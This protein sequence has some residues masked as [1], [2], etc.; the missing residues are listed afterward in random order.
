MNHSQIWNG[1]HTKLVT[2]QCGQLK[3]PCEK[4]SPFY[5]NLRNLWQVDYS[6]RAFQS[7]LWSMRLKYRENPWWGGSLKQSLSL[8]V[9]E[10][11]FS[12]ISRDICFVTSWQWRQLLWKTHNGT[13]IVNADTAHPLTIMC[14]H[15][16][17]CNFQGDNTNRQ[18]EGRKSM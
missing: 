10:T 15:Q 4:L 18:R 3:Y 1:I 8:Y 7:Y 16:K 5:K 11:S 9:R 2:I 17:D 12:S 6:D 13:G 14:F